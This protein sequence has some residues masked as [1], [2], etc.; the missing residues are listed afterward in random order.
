[1]AG[2]AELERLISA[3]DKLVAAEPGDWQHDTALRQALTNASPDQVPLFDEHARRCRFAIAPSGRRPNL[4]ER[5]IYLRERTNSG[6]FVSLS[7]PSGYERQ[8][9]LDQISHVPSAFCLGLVLYRLNDWVDEVRVTASHTIARLAPHLSN[10]FLAEAFRFYLASA[11]WG[12]I[13]DTGRRLLADLFGSSPVRD[14]AFRRVM[15]GR[16]NAAP[17][18]LRRMLRSADWDRLLPQL[19]M[20]AR[21]PAVR[22]IALRTLLDG[23]YSWRRNGL[24]RRDVTIAFDRTALVDAALTARSAATRLI[25]LRAF[26]GTLDQNSGQVERLAELLFDRA[27]AVASSAA[28]WLSRHSKRPAQ[29]LRDRL[30]SGG[31][32]HP[33]TLL[34]LGQIGEPGDIPSLSEIATRARHPK[35]IAALTSAGRLGSLDAVD[36]L[37]GLATSADDRAAKAASLAL[38]TLR[39]PMPLP[40]L[41]SE[42]RNPARFRSRRLMPLMLTHRPWHQ[43]AVILTLVQHGASV[44]G[45]E[46]TTARITAQA[47]HFWKPTA[48]E[49]E[50]LRAAFAGLSDVPACLTELHWLA[51]R[52]L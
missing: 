5:E 11:E 33:A 46:G 39:E 15:Q 48:E 40:A 25:A 3:I 28:F 44:P 8:R 43:L 10:E 21:H 18:T 49:L 24:A 4:A 6:V 34:M 7:S 23:H 14:E 2:G 38:A 41:L 32:C 27:A 9:A 35:A 42:A 16:A 50:E 31:P 19:A 1:M 45:I 51:R 12:R 20:S 17:T 36:A 47:R 37:I 29:L 30:A 22:H 26:A 52:P 13:D